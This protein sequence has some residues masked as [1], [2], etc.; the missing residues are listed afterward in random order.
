MSRTPSDA[1]RIEARICRAYR[2]GINYHELMRLVFPDPRSWSYSA[3]GGPPGCAMA[4]GAA[5]NR[6][7]A[8]VDMYRGRRVSIPSAALQRWREQKKEGE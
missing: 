5:L 2:E 6:L 7:G 3:N 1:E 4:F 8:Y